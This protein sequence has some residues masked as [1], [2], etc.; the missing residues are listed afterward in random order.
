MTSN[1]SPS[2]RVLAEQATSVK[3]RERL[4]QAS[5]ADRRYERPMT[6]DEAAALLDEIEALRKA[7]GLAQ[8]V[9]DDMIRRGIAYV[10]VDDLDAASAPGRYFIG[11]GIIAA[12]HEA[13]T[14][15]R[16]ALNGEKT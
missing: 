12:L 1:P 5:D 13:V 6:W 16:A 10:P 14:P 8:V 15:A 11:K 4:K 2:L 3:I 9:F 7:V